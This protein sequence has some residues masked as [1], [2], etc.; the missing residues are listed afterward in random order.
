MHN[1]HPH[2]PLH[3]LPQPARAG[4]TPHPDID[5]IL[6]TRDGIAVADDAAIP[7]ARIVILLDPT[8][9]VLSARPNRSAASFDTPEF[10]MLYQSILANGGNVTPIEV[11][12]LEGNAAIYELVSGECRLRACILARVQ[13]L[14]ML[15]EPHTESNDGLNRLRENTGRQELRPWDAGQQVR[16][17]YEQLK[18]ISGVELAAR[19]GMSQA[20]IS[21]ALDIS[22]LPQAMVDAFPSPLD[23]QVEHVKKLKTA[24]TQDSDAVL[25]ATETI[26]EEKQQG[27]V[28]SAK[29]VIKRIIDAVAAA[30]QPD[31]PPATTPSVPSGPFILACDGE[32]YG[33]LKR[34]ERGGREL[35]IDSAMSDVQEGLLIKAIDAFIRHT[36]RGQP[37]VKKQVRRSAVEVA[38]LNAAAALLPI[39]QI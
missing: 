36:V 13:V 27:A 15:A 35:H 33:Q 17:V 2:H 38:S 22:S 32:P 11:R 7:L 24:W 23:I 9:V 8:T 39:N 16:A 26:K 6:S 31:W 30:T 37:K 25:L 1:L 14:A 4:S 18:P 12:R 21:R 29:D 19:L 20:A 10:E 3:P 5:I 28:V 34:N